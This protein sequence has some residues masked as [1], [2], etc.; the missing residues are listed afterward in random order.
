MTRGSDF[1]KNAKC[2]DGHRSALGNSAWCDLNKICTVLKLHDMCHKP[3]CKCQKQI[4]FT[5]THF[6]LESGSIKSKL[7]KTFRGTK[8]LG[9][10]FLNRV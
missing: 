4:T 3:K 6:Q 9:I 7:Q 10:V 8:K 1:N 5:P 2:S